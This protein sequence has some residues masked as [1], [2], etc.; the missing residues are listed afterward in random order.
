MPRPKLFVAADGSIRAVHSDEATT[1]LA[2]VGSARVRRATHI[3]VTADLSNSAICAADRQGIATSKY[4]EHFW[5]H[6]PATDQ[7]LGPFTTYGEAV[8]AELAVLDDL[9]KKGEFVGHV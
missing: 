8:T 3:E 4:P 9:M 1:F 2:Q 6:I 7:I 5:A